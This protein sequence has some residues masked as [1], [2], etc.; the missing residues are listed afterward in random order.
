MCIKFP[1]RHLDVVVEHL[2]SALSAYGLSVIYKVYDCLRLTGRGAALSGLACPQAEQELLLALIGVLP[3]RLC[4]F[5]KL[6]GSRVLLAS[7]DQ[8]SFENVLCRCHN[9]CFADLRG[10]RQEQPC[11]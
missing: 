9:S 2:K 4:C 3:K 6:Q 1:S 10:E 5:H 8:V 7:S 11:R